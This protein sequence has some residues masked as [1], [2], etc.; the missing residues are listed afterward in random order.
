MKKTIKTLEK[1]CLQVCD[2]QMDN[3]KS[4]YSKFNYHVPVE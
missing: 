2:P 4:P 3:F 1:N